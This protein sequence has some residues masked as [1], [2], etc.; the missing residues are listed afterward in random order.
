MQCTTVWPASTYAV[1]LM[2]PCG[3]QNFFT[4]ADMVVWIGDQPCTSVTVNATSL[5]SATCTAPPGPGRG[6]VQLRV[7]VSGAV[8]ST[9]F[10]YDSPRG[11]SVQPV[12]CDAEATCTLQVGWAVD[13]CFLRPWMSP[14]HLCGPCHHVC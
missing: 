3:L 6:D 8:A 10:A 2:L 5:A 7:N 12:L 9:G 13:L 4:G 14:V 1:P 11:V